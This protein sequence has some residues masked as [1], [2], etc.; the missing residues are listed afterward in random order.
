MTAVCA[1]YIC[2]ARI[3]LNLP[4]N[5]SSW[6]GGAAAV[7]ALALFLSRCRRKT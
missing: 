2:H 1:T 6:M 7:L 5:V 4:L 3:G